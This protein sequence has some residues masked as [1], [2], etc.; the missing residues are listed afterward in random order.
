MTKYNTIYLINQNNKETMEEN[1]RVIAH[2]MENDIFIG[3]DSI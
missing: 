2:F 1:W 3:L